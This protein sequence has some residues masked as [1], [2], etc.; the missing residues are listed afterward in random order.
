[1]LWSLLEGVGLGVLL[2]VY[3]LIGI[4]GGAVGMVYLYHK[5][6]QDRCV[7]LGIT[8]HEQIKKRAIIFKISGI[9]SYIAYSLVFVYAVNGTRGFLQGFLQILI[10]LFVC[11]VIDRIFVDE[12]WVC[13]TKTWIIPGT[14]DLMPYITAKDKCKKWLF[15]TV[16]IAI[17][18][19]I[20]AGIMALIVK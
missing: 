5:D 8:T 7:E 6:V 10:I 1:M 3:C 15:G 14:E 20:L 12:L 16:G 18:A 2:F 9:L 19:V 13:H 4:K 11:N 17:Y